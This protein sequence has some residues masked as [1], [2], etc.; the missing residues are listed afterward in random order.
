MKKVF[1]LILIGFTIP[2]FA[3]KD[4]LQLGDRYA[5]DQLYMLISYNQLIDQPLSVD[6]SGLSYGLSAGF[7]KDVTLNR[8][9]SISLA[10][11]L[12]YNF[13]LYNHG[14]V[15]SEQNNE[16]TFQAGN[17]FTSNK[18]LTHNLEFPLQLRWRNSDANTYKFWRIYMGIKASHNLSNNFKFLNET[19]S[20]SYKNIPQFNS[21]QYGVTL[22]VGYDV[23][24]AHAYYGL[25]PILENA[26]I[27]STEISSK[28][29]KIGLI[30]YLL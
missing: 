22:S 13:D 29:L 23:F 25:N 11:G 5:E 12:G 16:I 9:G 2:F 7:I 8:R 24:T 17:S 15:I 18:L 30:F 21:W 20:L 4:S 14:L 19:T 1:F 26:M 28:I 3:Q 10:M 6:A 27:G